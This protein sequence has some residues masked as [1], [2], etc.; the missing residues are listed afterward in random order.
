MN[1]F[2]KPRI[3][4]IRNNSSN[5]LSTLRNLKVNREGS[6][7]RVKEYTSSTNNWKGLWWVLVMA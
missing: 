1:N 6:L 5:T 4:K 3:A 7:W 2:R